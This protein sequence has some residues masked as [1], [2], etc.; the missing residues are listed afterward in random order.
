M[1]PLLLSS[2]PPS[3]RPVPPDDGGDCASNDISTSGD[4]PRTRPP[5]SNDDDVIYDRYSLL[6]DQSR[7]SGEDA[8]CV[9]ASRVHARIREMPFDEVIMEKWDQV[10]RGN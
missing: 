9:A 4:D 7:Q 10:Q 3:S 2:P 8:S 5:L 1:V 6:H